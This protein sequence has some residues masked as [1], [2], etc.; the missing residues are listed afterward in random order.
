MIIMIIIISM[1]WMDSVAPLYCQAKYIKIQSLLCI[2]INFK[3]I[4]YIT[5]FIIQRW[6]IYFLFLPIM[7]LSFSTFNT[8]T[9]QI[10]ERNKSKVM[11]ELV[12]AL[13]IQQH[14][15]VVYI[16]HITAR[17]HHT[18][19]SYQ[20]QDT[21]KHIHSHLLLNYYHSYY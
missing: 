11:L 4:L 21:Q 15:Y 18:T 1:V 12:L 9:N 17:I 16:N 6:A 13:Y 19:K 3:N 7:L 20:I 2:I 14:I 8:I 10:S 5:M